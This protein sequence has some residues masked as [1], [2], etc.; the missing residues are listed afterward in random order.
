MTAAERQDLIMAT[1]RRERTATISN[2]AAACGCNARTIRRDIEALSVSGFPVE[3]VQGNGGG[4]RLAEWYQPH[5]TTLGPEQLEV[6][7]RFMASALPADRAVLG[8]IIDQ[9]GPRR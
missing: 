1:L 6:L 9:F 3:T 7:Q 2:F 8:S 5:R 4:V